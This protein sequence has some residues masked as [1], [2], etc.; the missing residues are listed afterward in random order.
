MSRFPWRLHSPPLCLC[1][2]LFTLREVFVNSGIVEV[3]NRN[4]LKLSVTWFPLS[5]N[6]DDNPIIQG[7][8]EDQTKHYMYKNFR[9]QI[10]SEKIHCNHIHIKNVYEITSMSIM[11]STA[12]NKGS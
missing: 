9:M 2:M 11:Q 6:R 4:L 3:L 12:L 8:C 7:M 1:R 10:L 5:L